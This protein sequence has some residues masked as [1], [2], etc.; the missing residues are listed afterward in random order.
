MV[1]ESIGTPSTCTVQAPQEESSQPRLEPVS[2]R[3]WRN[4]SSSNLLG[5]MANSYRRPLILSSIN[6]F[7][8]FNRGPSAISRQPNPVPLKADGSMK[9]S[10]SKIRL[11]GKCM[12]LHAKILHPAAAQLIHVLAAVGNTVHPT[13]QPGVAIGLRLGLFVVLAEERDVA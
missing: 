3:S 4:A 2:C 10:I 1:Q 12:L 8:I 11:C 9:A 13:F 6:S 5:S 7:F